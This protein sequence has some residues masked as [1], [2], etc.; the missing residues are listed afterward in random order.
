MKVVNLALYFDFEIENR[1]INKFKHI[2]TNCAYT[3]TKPK[4]NCRQRSN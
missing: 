4:N 1:L 3:N 2:K